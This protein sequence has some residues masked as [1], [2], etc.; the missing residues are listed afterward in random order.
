MLRIRV[1]QEGD[2]DI[3]NRTEDAISDQLAD[4]LSNR[5]IEEA[6][7][8]L[9]LTQL[10]V[11]AAKKGQ[12]IYLYVYCATLEELTALYNLLVTGAVKTIVE[13]LFNKLVSR[14]DRIVVSYTYS[15]EEYNKCKSYFEGQYFLVVLF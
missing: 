4:F 2:P 13:T 11:I 5:S 10:K 9:E 1:S 7:R 15:E 8:I 12:S 6:Q 14:E 3:V